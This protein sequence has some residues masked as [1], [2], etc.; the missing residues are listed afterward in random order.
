MQTINFNDKAVR[1][2]LWQIAFVVGLLGIGYVLVTNLLTNLEARSIRSGYDYLG[3]EAGFRIG[4][5]LISYGP[6]DSY[7]RAVIVGFLNTLKVSVV[8]LVIATVLGVV[9]G[10]GR[11]SENLA[12][13]KFTSFYVDCFRN[14]P[15]LLQLFFWYAV[16]TGLLPVARDAL[17][18]FGIAFL[19]KSGL[20]FPAPLATQ[21]NYAIGASFV[22]GVLALIAFFKWNVRQQNLT[23]QRRSLWPPALIC[24]LIL[25]LVAWAATG[26]PVDFSVPAQ[27]RFNFKGGWTA[28]PEFLALALGLSLYS[29]AFIAENVRGGIQSVSSGQREAA[30]ALGLRSG[31]T[32]WLI[33]LPQALRVIIPPT[34]GQ[35]LNLIKNSSLAVAI[36]YPDLVSVS[37]TTLNQTGQ[38]LE[39]VSIMMAVYLTISL[40]VSV[41]MNWYNERV[42]LVSR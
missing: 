21:A 28:T 3:R 40:S 17:S 33:V 36:G 12:L 19:S 10:I 26:F 35:Y 13:R 23:G 41:G 24:L 27:T 30:Q 42:A 37:N 8:S 39:A 32:M 15:L 38:A 5:S 16:L 11:L 25:P 6:E 22:I 14:T 4:E 20:I 9:I 1:G 29:A 2:V 31:V 34:T 18:F 7:G